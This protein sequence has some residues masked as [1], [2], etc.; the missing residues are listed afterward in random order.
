MRYPTNGVPSGK[1]CREVAMEVFFGLLWL[2]TSWIAWRAGFVAGMNCVEGMMREK[3][4][5]NATTG[6]K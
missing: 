2:V 4:A 5:P 3:K 6:G 1:A